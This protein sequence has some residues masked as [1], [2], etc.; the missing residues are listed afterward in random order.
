MHERMLF[1]L[2]ANEEYRSLAV[3]ARMRITENVPL[4]AVAARMRRKVTNE[5]LLSR[6]R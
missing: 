4:L 6:D 2:Q 3:A 1:L 5:K